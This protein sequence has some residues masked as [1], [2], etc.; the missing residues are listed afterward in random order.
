MYRDADPPGWQSLN[1]MHNAFL[2]AA[3]TVIALHAY[4]DFSIQIQ[5]VAYVLAALT[6]AGTAQARIRRAWSSRD[7][8]AQELR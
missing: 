8:L 6:G 7:S 3:I 2:G 5:S 4:V 1:A